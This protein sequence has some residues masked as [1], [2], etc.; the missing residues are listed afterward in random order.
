MS[1][2]VDAASAEVRSS[3]AATERPNS[4]ASG[5]FAA[6]WEH[7]KQAAHAVGVV[8]TRLLMI[9]FFFLVVFPLGLLM[10]IGSD[11][12]HLKRPSGSSWVPHEHQEPSLES[13]HRQF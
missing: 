7:W 13:A 2:S 3:L 11:K 9:V 5:F 8:Q 6:V 4:E 10:R 1:D 12:L